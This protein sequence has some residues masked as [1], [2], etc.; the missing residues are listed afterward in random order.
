MGKTW[1]L[2]GYWPSFV[3]LLTSGVLSLSTEL[4]CVL[5]CFV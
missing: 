5:L 3:P 1:E 2:L 4:L